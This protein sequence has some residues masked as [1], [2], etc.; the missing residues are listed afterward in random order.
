MAGEH[1]ESA[2]EELAL[3]L[4]QGISAAKW[5]RAN[6]VCKMTAYRWAKEPEVREMVESYRRRVI[7]QAIGRLAKR[8]VSAVEGIAK[9][10]SDAESESVRLSACRAILADTIA[11]SRHWNLEAKVAI[12]EEWYEAER[13]AAGGTYKARTPLNLS[14]TSGSRTLPGS[15][16]SSTGP[17]KSSPTSHLPECPPQDSNLKPAD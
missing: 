10:A 9:L 14:A 16:G 7:D 8:T 17:E 2:K 11:V 6:D 3:A 4:A 12:V 5:A 1:R 15:S 13:A